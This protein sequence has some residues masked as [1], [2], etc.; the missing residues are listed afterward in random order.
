MPEIEENGRKDDT[1]DEYSDIED[2]MH[3]EHTEGLNDL[4]FSQTTEKV[5]RE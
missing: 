4:N 5:G 3:S 1:G 2:R